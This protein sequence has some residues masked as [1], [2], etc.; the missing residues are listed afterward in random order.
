MIL[1]TGG[2]GQ[3]GRALISSLEGSITAP[4]RREMDIS[5]FE[6]TAEY[7]KAIRPSTVIHCAAYNM[8][9]KAEYDRDTCMAVNGYGTGNIARV[10]AEVGAYFIYISTDFVFDGKKWE[11]Y[12]PTDLPCPVS[13][14]GESKFLGE[15][16]TLKYPISLVI[17]TAW[18]FS[19]GGNNFVSAILKAAR[20]REEIS[21]V[22]DQRGSPTYAHDLAITIKQILTIRP[23]GIIHITN[24]GSCTRADFARE[25]LRQAGLQTRVRD[26]CSSEFPR[27]ARRPGNVVL[28]KS[29]L[30][31][32]GI[33]RLP[34]WQDGLARYLSK[35]K[36]EHNS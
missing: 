5:D 8:V 20:D 3:L 33:C 7:I 12:E 9:D 35:S 14:Y 22:N 1:I 24:E 6:G 2:A 28:S 13:V 25:I 29:C 36:W 31:A 10:C 26:V 21:V 34:S 11:E 19:E 23:F 27:A 32:V 4:S 18:L 15:K 16:E 17:R 30:D